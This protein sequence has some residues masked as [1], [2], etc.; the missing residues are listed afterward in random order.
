MKFVGWIPCVAGELFFSK[1]QVGL[2]EADRYSYNKVTTCS[3]T[4]AFV[5]RELLLTSLVDWQD[6]KIWQR[7]NAGLTRVLV[8]AEADTFTAVTGTVYFVLKGKVPQAS[9]GWLPVANA[10]PENRFLDFL[11]ALTRASR[12]NTVHKKVK[13]SEKDFEDFAQIDAEIENIKQVCK[14]HEVTFKIHTNG[15]VFLEYKGMVGFPCTTGPEAEAERT[16]CR[17]AFHFLK[18]SFHKHTHHHHHNESLTDIHR[19]KCGLC[20]LETLLRDL[21]RGMVDAKRGRKLPGFK[22]SGIGE[23]GKSLISSTVPHIRMFDGEASP[24]GL[25][26]KPVG[27]GYLTYDVESQITLFNSLSKSLELQESQEKYFRPKASEQDFFSCFYSRLVVVNILLTP[28]FIYLNIKSGKVLKF[29]MNRQVGGN[30]YWEKAIEAFEQYC[31]HFDSGNLVW[32]GGFVLLVLSTSLVWAAIRFDWSRSGFKPY[33][34]IVDGVSAKIVNSRSG[35]LGWGMLCLPR[36][37]LVRIKNHLYGDFALSK[38]SLLVQSGLARVGTWMLYGFGFYY[39][40]L[41]FVGGMSQ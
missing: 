22:P 21:K 19:V 33:G 39:L 29:L 30:L 32:L 7:K 14:V 8:R 16:V 26:K 18:Y 40:Y 35:S 13:T 41:A 25:H 4:T 38:L 37:Y 1:T 9:L 6:S 20:S 10:E 11:G 12:E 2:G 28:L 36:M 5:K 23:Y 31:M 27:V 17:Q 15:V 34:K 3:K 24:C